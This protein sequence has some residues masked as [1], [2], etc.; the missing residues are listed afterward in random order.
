MIIVI[1][2]PAGAGKSTTAK[3]IARRTGYDYVDSGAVYRG[4][5]CLYLSLGEDQ[6][7]FLETLD[8]HKLHF[9][10]NVA[11]ARAFLSDEEITDAIRTDAVNNL[12]SEVAAMPQVRSAV[13]RILRQASNGSNVILEGRDLGTVVF[14]DADYKFFLTADPAARAKD[15]KSVV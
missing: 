7:R 15:R 10:F 5:T 11:E 9:V 14:P 6:S 3:E 2:G 13:Q 8:D 1:D 4:F 12:V